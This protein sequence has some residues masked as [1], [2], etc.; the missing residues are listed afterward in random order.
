MAKLLRLFFVRI[1]CA[2]FLQTEFQSFQSL[3]FNEWGL[4]RAN[5]D[6]WQSHEC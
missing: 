5:G 4:L 6:V 1:F 2:M 3:Y